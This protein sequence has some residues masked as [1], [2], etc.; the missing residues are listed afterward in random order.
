[1][2][3]KEKQAK[4]ID[5]AIEAFKTERLRWIVG[6]SSSGSKAS[7]KKRY[8]ELTETVTSDE[9]ERQ[10]L[11]TELKARGP[12]TIGDL[13]QATGM[14]RGIVLKHIIAL[15]RTRGITEIGERNDEYLYA[16]S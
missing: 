14:D 8:E 2:S 12:M 3:E 1:M 13:S 10:M 11:L 15:R 6:L 4:K 9:I 16:V 7:E 5:A